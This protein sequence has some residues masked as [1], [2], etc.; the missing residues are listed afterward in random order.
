[1]AP[2]GAIIS[3]KIINRFMSFAADQASLYKAD[4]VSSDT[5]QRVIDDS[6]AIY[7]P[8]TSKGRIIS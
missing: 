1:M 4:N 8:T 7:S 3:S 6:F 2:E 5:L